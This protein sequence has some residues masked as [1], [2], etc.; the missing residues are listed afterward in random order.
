MQDRWKSLEIFFWWL[1]DLFPELHSPELRFPESH[2][3][4]SLFLESHFSESRFPESH[5]LE[6]RFTES[7]LPELRFP[8]SHFLES[9]GIGSRGNGPQRN[10][11]T[12]KRTQSDNPPFFLK[13]KYCRGNLVFSEK[14]F[15][16]NFRASLSVQQSPGHPDGDKFILI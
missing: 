9:R 14:L 15:R 13:E 10:D 4:E 6:S 3:P 11:N 7:H 1:D 12:G 8:E 5:F 2:F 16:S